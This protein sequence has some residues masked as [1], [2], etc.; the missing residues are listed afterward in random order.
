MFQGCSGDVPGVFWGVLGVFRGCF[1]GVPGCSG[2]FRGCSG[3]V[4][5][6]FW[7]LQ[8]PYIFSDFSDISQGSQSGSK[9]RVLAF[10][11][12]NAEDFSLKGFD[13]AAKAVAKL[14]DA[15]PEFKI[16]SELSA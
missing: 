10:G 3:G 16:K 4:P 9:C 12:G 11:L 5:G 2:V 7:V 14:N 13:I 1:G 8:T 6:L 15:C